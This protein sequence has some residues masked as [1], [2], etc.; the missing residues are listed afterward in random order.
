[1][2]N[3]TDGPVL[4]LDRITHSQISELDKKRTMVIATM[5]PLEVHGPHLP[6]GQDLFEAYAI[7]EKTALKVSETLEGWSFILLPPVP[8]AIDCVPHLGSVNFP[9]KLVRDVAYH[10]LEPFAKKGF[11]RLAFSSFHGGPRHICSLESASMRLFDKYGIPTV[12][13]FSVVLSRVMEGDVFFEG[14]ENTPGREIDTMQLKQD[15]HGGFVETSLGLHLWPEYVKEGWDK[16]PPLVAVE[17]V[18]KETNDSF[19][20]GYDGDPTVLEKLRQVKETVASVYRSMKHFNEHT[21]FGYPA[22]ASTEQGRDL[23]EH[24]TGIAHDSICEFIEKGMEM[25]VHSPLWKFHGFLLNGAVNK[26][27]ND[28]L[29]LYS[30]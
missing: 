8:V 23:F 28:W 20:Y 14:I 22:M 9:V 27:A 5:S 12:S 1:M 25:D 3:L 4:R 11:A 26:V 18:S 17:N 6:L 21:Y 13:L 10:L 24:L 15:H 30:E 7:A 16:L 2:S 19:L 29:K